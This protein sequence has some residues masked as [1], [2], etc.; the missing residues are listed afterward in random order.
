MESIVDEVIEKGAIK[1]RKVAS[2]TLKE[3][4]EKMGFI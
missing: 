1:A 3:V 4:K 2:Q